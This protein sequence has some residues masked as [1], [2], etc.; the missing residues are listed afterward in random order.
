MSLLE[1]IDKERLP[2]HVAIIMDGNGRWAKKTGKMRIYGHRHGVKPVREATETCAELGIKYLTLYAF[3]TENW[4]R[5]MDEVGGLMSLLLNTLGSERNTLME[6]DVKLNCIGD[7]SSLPKEVLKKLNDTI[8]L[9]ANNKGLNLTLALSY[10]ARW[11]I[12]NAVK[13]IAEEVKSNNLASEHLTEEVFNQY[14]CTTN[15]PDPDLLI[16]TSG[17]MRISNLLLWTIA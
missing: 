9:T 17:E 3:S 11:E 6:N 1:N 12:L 5:P 13:K 16:S 4:K 7:T 8:E 10:S 14:L 15:M 2:Q